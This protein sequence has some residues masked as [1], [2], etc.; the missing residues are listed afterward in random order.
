MNDNKV[1]IFFATDDGYIPY[2]TVTLTSLKENCDKKR[3]YSIRILVTCISEEYKE[4]ITSQ[5][6]DDS[7]RVEFVDIKERIEYISE[8]LHTR[9]YYSKTT[10]YRLFIPN[11]FPELKKALYLDGDIVILGDIS[12]LYDTELEDNLVGAITDSFVSESEKLKL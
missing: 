3:F 5:F 8:K 9:D 10:Y 11:L 1:N 2:L 7:F 4:K 12:E 6:N